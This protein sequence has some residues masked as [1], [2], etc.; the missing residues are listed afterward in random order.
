LAQQYLG[1]GEALRKTIRRVAEAR[2]DEAMFLPA[3]L[4]QNLNIGA[5]A[6]YPSLKQSPA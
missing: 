6:K 3:F 2:C 4:Q 5:A 1:Q